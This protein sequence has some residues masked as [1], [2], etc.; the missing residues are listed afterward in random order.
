MDCRGVVMK[1][2]QITLYD[3]QKGV[4]DPYCWLVKIEHAGVIVKSGKHRNA[5]DAYVD[6]ENKLI[7]K[8]GYVQMVPIK[9]R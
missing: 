5:C 9:D 2:S 8:P 7:I 4:H 3:H 6:A 1:I